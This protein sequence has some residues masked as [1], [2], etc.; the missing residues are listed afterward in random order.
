MNSAEDR[1]PRD[2][3]RG[4]TATGEAAERLRP[5]LRQRLGERVQAMEAAGRRYRQGW[6]RSPEQLSRRRWH[7][8]WL[9]L[10]RLRDALLLLLVPA[11]AAGLVWLVLQLLLP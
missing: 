7:A 5:L 8:R 9:A 3:E 1:S 10:A 11:A 2:E 4:G 6:W